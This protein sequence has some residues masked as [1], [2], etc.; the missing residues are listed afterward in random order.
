MKE[1]TLSR[2]SPFRPSFGANPPLVAGRDA[3][4]AEFA[5][6]LD[7][8]P[9]AR[10]RACLFTGNRGIGKTVMLNEAEAAAKE[11]GWLV[12]SETATR[13]LLRRLTTEGLPRAADLLRQAP[14][15]PAPRAGGPAGAGAA[16]PPRGVGNPP[17]RRSRRHRAR[18]AGPRPPGWAA[19][20][21]RRA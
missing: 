15:E 7:T 3:I 16:R 5:D 13:G 17:P 2:R 6:A 4:V 9:G 12:V 21:A 11:R 20:P 8:G 19:A 1:E 18:P 10:G 14:R